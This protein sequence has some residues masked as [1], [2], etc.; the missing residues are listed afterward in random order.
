MQKRGSQAAG[1]QET[2]E[3]SKE[4]AMPSF[5]NSQHSN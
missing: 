1:A 3:N 5:C 2:E 4:N